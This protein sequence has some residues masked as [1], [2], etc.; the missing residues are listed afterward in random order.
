MVVDTM[1]VTFTIGL[2]MGLWIGISIAVL[3]D[4]FSKRREEAIMENVKKF[5]EERK[6]AGDGKEDSRAI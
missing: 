1:S 4:K 6:N 3:V 5:M 2:A